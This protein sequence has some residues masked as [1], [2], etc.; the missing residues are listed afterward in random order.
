MEAKAHAV[1]VPLNLEGTIV[2]PGDLVFSDPAN[3]VVV[4]PQDKVAKV[5]D[6]LPSMIAAD[7][8]VKDDVAAGVSVQ[9]SF[10][11]HRGQ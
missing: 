8:R 2:K 11:K 10:R 3:G 7:D 6:L 9:D 5:L 1:Q 4:I